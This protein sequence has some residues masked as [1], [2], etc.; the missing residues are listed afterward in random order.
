MRSEKILDRRSNTSPSFVPLFRDS[1]SARE[2]I[3]RGRRG[4]GAA[5]SGRAKPHA[6]PH[7]AR[8]EPHA[9]PHAALESR[10]QACT[11]VRTRPRRPARRPGRGHGD[12]LELPGQ[13]KLSPS[14]AVEAD[15]MWKAPGHRPPAPGPSHNRWKS[16]PPSTAPGF[17]QLRTASATRSQRGRR[18]RRK[19]QIDTS[20]YP[21]PG[22]GG[23][24]PPGH[25]RELGRRG[26]TTHP[27]TRS[28]ST[29]RGPTSLPPA[30]LT[31]APPRELRPP[32][33]RRTQPPTRSRSSP[34]RHDQPPPVP[35]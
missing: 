9:S 25:P 22:L 24:L 8:A 4:V 17:P 19:P 35:R 34:P 20:L 1:P 21:S 15:R 18:G 2:P 12:S 7:A 16:R 27:P 11:Q 10:T 30:A 13:A 5:E 3:R 29:V 23:R 28:R 26:T 31:Q 6:G 33:G 32:S 14:Q